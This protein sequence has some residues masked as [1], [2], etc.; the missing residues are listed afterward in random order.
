MAKLTLS[1]GSNLGDRRQLL[2]LAREELQRQLGPLLYE[3]EIVSNPPW[4]PVPQEDYLNQVVVV[5]VDVPL[6]GPGIA[7]ALHRILDV[8]QSIELAAGRTRD[9]RWGPRTLDIDVIFLEDIMYE[10]ARLSVPHPWWQQRSF[11]T[12]LLPAGLLDPY[13]R[14]LDAG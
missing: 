5:A 10:D 11:V 14:I 1:L 2:K 9:Q 7:T 13:G 8:T 6:S 12:D 3:S 4:G